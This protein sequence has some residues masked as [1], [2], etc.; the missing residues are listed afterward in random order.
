MTLLKASTAG[1]IG[2]V[3][4]ISDTSRLYADPRPGRWDVQSNA[5]HAPLRSLR[6]QRP[7]DVH[8]RPHQHSLPIR[9]PDGQYE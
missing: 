8:A 4:G 1:T 2:L 6:L 7:R 9:G 5:G 3:A